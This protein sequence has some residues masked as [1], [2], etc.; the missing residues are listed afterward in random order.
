MAFIKI[1]AALREKKVPRRQDQRTL[2]IFE[3][4]AFFCG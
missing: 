2:D 4:F 3:F 1:S